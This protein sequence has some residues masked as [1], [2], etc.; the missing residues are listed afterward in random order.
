MGTLRIKGST[1]G[2]IDIVANAASANYT[3][4]L[5][6]S[7]TAIEEKFLKS[8]ANGNLLFSFVTSAPEGFGVTG[9]L[10]VT[11]NTSI[12][13]ELNVA[14]NLV[15]GGQ[16]NFS[17]PVLT[18]NSDIPAETI[19]SENAGIEV[20][21]GNAL[22]TSL[23]WNESTD[24][25]VFTNDGTSYNNLGS[26]ASEVYAN[27]AYEQANT[28]NSIGTISG[29]YANVAYS[30]AN[31]TSVYAN[32]A[33]A[34]ANSV[35]SSST[36]T[37]S[38]ANSAFESSNSASSYANGAFST[39]NSK[40]S[41]AG[42]SITGDVVVTGNLTV[43]GET[44]YANTQNLLIADNIVVLNASADQT[45]APS[46]NAGIEVDRGSSSNVSL[47]WNE[48]TD[49]WTFTNDGTNYSSIA[50][51][52]A[53]IY[54]NAAYDQANTAN[55]TASS[56]LSATLD[57]PTV[58]SYANAAY[59][60][61]N[62]AND[63][64]SSGSVYANAA[65]GQANTANDTASSGSVYANAAYGQ[66]NTANSIAAISGDYAN[67]A[68]SSA[69]AAVATAGAALSAATA[70]DD[71]TASNPSYWATSAPTTIQAAVDR[72]AN[73]VYTLNSNTQIP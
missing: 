47:L 58:S 38:Y 49:K 16:I 54:A 44:T 45:A 30:S 21:R 31:S 61:A 20:K 46:V 50:S 27:A 10:S 22:T 71:F 19:P 18:L 48:S 25:W 1:S 2:Y 65:F 64:A 12:G 69:N 33:F 7:N 68:Y 29:S 24:K 62:T 59:G 70:A 39:A 37:A 43:V 17:D 56:A 11:Q 42:G 13:G 4:R 3:L 57:I 36:V 14:G 52:A 41:S 63:T 73:L 55:T 34:I 67:S 9:N 32:A 26:A 53:E 15:I 23:L 72:L 28:A 51:A 60:Q 5:P 66:A 6:A 35:S 8:D 40:F